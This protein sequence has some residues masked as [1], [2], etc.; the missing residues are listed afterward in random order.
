M[1][2]AFLTGIALV[3]GALLIPVAS[4]A[5]ARTGGLRAATRKG[6]TAVNSSYTAKPNIEGRSPT[7]ACSV[8][9]PSRR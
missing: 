8:S 1:K 5:Q 7:A 6:A 4:P 9:S 3:A 2:R